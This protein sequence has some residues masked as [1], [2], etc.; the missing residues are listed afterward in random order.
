MR[1][2]ERVCGNDIIKDFGTFAKGICGDELEGWMN[3]R[4]LD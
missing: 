2:L 3:E 4:L 1:C